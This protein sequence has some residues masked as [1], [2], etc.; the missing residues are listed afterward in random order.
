MLFAFANHSLITT[1]D[2]V[3]DTIKSSAKSMISRFTKYHWM[4]VQGTYSK[5]VTKLGKENSPQEE[6]QQKLDGHS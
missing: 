1:I 6:E 5:N 4:G 3:W 2:A